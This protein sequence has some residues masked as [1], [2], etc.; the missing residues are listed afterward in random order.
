MLY[1]VSECDKIHYTSKK[2]T[3]THFEKNRKIDFRKPDFAELAPDHKSNINQTYT[4]HNHRWTVLT[5]YNGDSQTNTPSNQK[6]TTKCIK[7]YIKNTSQT[8]QK[9]SKNN[10]MHQNAKR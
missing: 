2:K 10:N 7:K 6:N 3:R 4:E 5:K 1:Y 9:A 8:H